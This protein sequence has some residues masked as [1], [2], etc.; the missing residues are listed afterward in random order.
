MEG[1]TVPVAELEAPPRG[2][3]L[4]AVDKSTSEGEHSKPPVGLATPE[5]KG[6]VGGAPSSLVAPINI[7]MR[8]MKKVKSKLL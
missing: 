7:N 3:P 1:Q 8:G 5:R 2:G 6:E 4:A